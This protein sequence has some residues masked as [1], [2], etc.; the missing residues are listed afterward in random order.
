M[1]YEKQCNLLAS[2]ILSV[3]SSMNTKELSEYMDAMFQHYASEG[4][5]L[6][7]PDMKFYEQME[8]NR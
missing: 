7:D 2:G 1:P 4:I 5:R 6:T 3:S 8:E